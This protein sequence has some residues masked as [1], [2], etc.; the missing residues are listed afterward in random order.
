M[1]HL[2]HITRKLCL[3]ICSH[4]TKLM[5]ACVTAESGSLEITAAAYP[6]MMLTKPMTQPVTNILVLHVAFCSDARYNALRLTGSQSFHL[7]TKS[8][9]SCKLLSLCW[10]KSSSSLLKNAFFFS[11][12]LGSIPPC[13][14]LLI[15]P[16]QLCW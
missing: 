12:S 5:V 11:P 10:K 8:L 6:A 13:F 1:T 16:L 7:I 3:G 14:S 9:D 15:I 2:L 4:C